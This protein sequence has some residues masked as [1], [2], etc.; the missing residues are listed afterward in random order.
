MALDQVN[1]F[2]KSTVT[3]GY[4]NVAT[5][6]IVT[7]GTRFPDPA[8]G[9]FNVT[10]WNSTDY[11]DP[12]DDPNREIVRVTAKVTNTLTVTRAQEGTSATAKNT[13]DKTYTMILAPTAKLITDIETE[14]DTKADGAAS[15]TDNALARFDSTTGKVLQNSVVTVGDTGV[16]AGASIS[17]SD[18]T[19]TNV[20][21]STAVSGL[22]A[23]VATFLGT[24]SSANLAAALTDETG[25]GSAVFANSP[26]L[27]TPALGTPSSATLTNATGLPISTGVSGLGANVATFLATPSSANLAAAVTDETGSGALVFGTSPSLTTPNLGTPSAATLTNATGLPLTTGVTGTLPLANGGTGAS[28]ADPGEDKLMFWDD[29]AASTAYLTVGTGL[30]ISGT[31]ITATGSG[32][33]DVVGPASATDN[34]IVRFDLT[35]GKL[36]QDSSVT[37]S[38]AGVVAGASISGSTNTIT[39]VSLATGVTGN[40]PVTNLNSG[41][42]ASGSTFWRGDGVWATPAGGGDVSGPAS[43]TDNAIARFDLTTGKIIQDSAVTI[44]NSGV[45]AGASISGS[46]NTFTNIPLS[47][48]VTGQLPLAN[49]GTGANLSD[50]NADRILFWDDSAGATTWL[51]VGSGLTITDTTITASGSGTPGGSDTQV[52]YNNAGAFGGITGATT[53]GTSMTLTSPTLITPALGTPA[54]GTLTNCT[55][56]PISSGVSGLGAN[57]ATFLATPSSANLAAAVTDETGSGALVFATSPTLVTPTLGVATATSINKVTVTAPATSATLTLADGSSLVT[58]GANSI[59]L[60]STGATNVTLP[61]TGTLATLAGSETLTNKTL[62]APIISSI[63]NTGTLTLPTSTDTLVGRAT[64]DTLTKK[65]ITKRVT[66]IT[67][68][69]T[70]TVNTD[71]CD[72]VDITALAA[73]ITSMTTNLSGTPTNFQSLIYRIKD[74]GTARAITWGA[75]FAANGVALPTTTVISK[76][77]TVGFIW[78]G[79]VWGCVASV[80]EA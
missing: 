79:S 21:I 52:Q 51:T 70:P 36:V 73:A 59:T 8:S 54:S 12:A 42:S 9:E 19:I 45:M 10:W 23:N 74:N 14:L 46:S 17:G 71:N 15:S 26:T 16:M 30:L 2:G 58:S 4:S 6:I 56:L 40:L 18:N 80:Q 34:A 33:G 39:N 63:S 27:V 5:S 25:T 67:S 60:T 22:G 76:L 29:S 11:F 49:G 20:A 69:A 62:T 53:D 38:D 1:N 61:T 47:T 77:L 68:N 37:I 7:D 64:T 65:R 72:C 3:T 24:P 75:S 44:D 35:T 32:T 55:G 43:A 28:L 31:T 50:P 78:N 48:G 41:T 66:T 13:A 57:V